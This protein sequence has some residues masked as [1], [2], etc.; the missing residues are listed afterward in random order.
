MSTQPTDQDER[1]V[2]MCP[3]HGKRVTERGSALR[4]PAGH[5]VTHFDRWDRHTNKAVRVPVD[6]N[7]RK[8]G[9]TV[10]NET[11][12]R[13]VPVAPPAAAKTKARKLVVLER[14]K[15]VDDV[16]NVLW[17]RLI[18]QN[19]RNG[20]VHVVRWF[21]HPSGQKVKSKTAPVAADIFIEP[22]RT[23]YAAELAK[24][25]KDG[26]REV[27]ILRRELLFAV[28]PKPVLKGKGR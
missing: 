11:T 8:G 5:D 2:R 28:P 3:V 17:L 25:K 9:L 27:L 19:T 12:A 15:L 16:G 1:Y 24:V 21:L 18:R 22:M 6:G 10:A 20:P 23:A 7:E 14:T 26:W 4:C 13:P